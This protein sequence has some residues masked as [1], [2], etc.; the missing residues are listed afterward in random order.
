MCLYCT[1]TAQADMANVLNN[2]KRCGAQ[3]IEDKPTSASGQTRS[4]RHRWNK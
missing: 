3:R 4:D 2:G 1:C